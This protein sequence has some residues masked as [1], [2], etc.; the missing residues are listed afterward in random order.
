MGHDENGGV[1]SP[2]SIPFFDL[3]SVGFWAA[4]KKKLARNLDTVPPIHIVAV[5]LIIKQRGLDSRCKKLKKAVLRQSKMLKNLLEAAGSQ[6]T[7]L[8]TIDVTARKVEIE[9]TQQ[10]LQDF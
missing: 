3:W 1:V 4:E 5:L 2:W 9:Q 6:G 7:V 8:M 10:L